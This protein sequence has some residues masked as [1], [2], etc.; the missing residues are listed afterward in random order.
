VRTDRGDA[1]SVEAV[2]FADGSPRAAPRTAAPGWLLAVASVLPQ[3]FTACAIVLA[4]AFGTKPLVSA[5]TRALEAASARG[6]AREVAGIPPARVRGALAGEPP[7]VAAAII[8]A[9][10]TATAAA[11]LELYPAEERTAIVRRLANANAALVPSP[12]ELVRGGA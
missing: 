9:L 6:A 2:A 8:S 10:P 1:V 3:A 11:V 7:H 4:V 5:A 12:E